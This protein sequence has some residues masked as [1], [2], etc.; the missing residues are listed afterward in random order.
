MQGLQVFS[1]PADAPRVRWRTDLI[2]AALTAVALVVLIA[3]AG[4]GS[5]LDTN[6][7]EFVGT[8][9]GWLLWLGQAIYELGVVYSLA[10]LIG[11]GLFAR[12]R[13]ELLRD[14]LL[15]A[16]LAAAIVVLLSRFIDE[17][18]PELPFLDLNETRD[19]FPAFF[20]AVAAAI[21]AAASPHLTAPMR[22]AGWTLILGAVAA[23]VLG[24]VTTTSDALG[25]LL[26]GLI[27]AALIRYLL[28]TTAG[29]PPTDRIRVALDDLG[30]HTAE[31]S[32][33]DAARQPAT[34]VVLTGTSTD[35][36][37]LF[38]RGLGRDS[39]S[40]RRWIRWWRRAWYQDRGSQ[41]GA[42]RRQQLEH[43]ALA[44][45]LARQ[46]GVPVPAFVGVGM[47][48]HEDG[49]LVT[50]WLDHTLE[51]VADVD[52]HTLDA[53]WAA[54]GASHRVGI[55]H[56]SLDSRHIWFDS[57]GAPALMGFDQAAINASDDQI[58]SDLAA[59]LVLTTLTV[60]A[61][62]AIAAARRAIGDESLA[63]MLP[64]LQ[65]AS[66]DATLRHRIKAQ[67]LKVDDLRKQTAEAL[68]TDVPA[69]EQLTRVTWK[70]LV[71]TGFVGF[72]VYSIIAGLADVGFGTI[73]DSFADARWSLVLLGLFLA[74]AT[75]Y[76]DS[77]AV[78]AVAPKP[79]PVGITTIEQFGIGF[80]NMAVPAP[81]GSIATNV[82]FFQKFGINAVA[83][84]TNGVITGF[85]G[86]AAQAIMI[87]FTILVGAGSVDLSAFEGGGDVIRPLL[88]ALVVLAIA[89][90]VAM[91]VPTWR[92]WTWHKI[93]KPL[94]Q[95]REALAALKNP[96]TAITALAGSIGT[97][98][99]YGAG[100][101]CCVLAMGGSLTLGQAIF[102][103]ITVSL[104]SAI[105][106][107]PGNAGVAEAG[108]TASLT[109][110][111]VPSST[112]VSAVLVYRLVSTYLPPIWGYFCM[113]WLVKRDYL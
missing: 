22:K 52:D 62:R 66:C 87:A 50:E 101:L 89:V 72:G 35:G 88:T 105:S 77:I 69:I 55:S 65:T 112:A 36:A 90:I 6:T 39:W 40:A 92:H 56:G 46:G 42:D 54:L 10:L 53:I 41:V 94:G 51:D 33:V 13:L 80:V 30:V 24:G 58:R 106:P 97:E 8:L 110:V 28:G 100:L 60:G 48:A 84:T 82:R 21:Q 17:R 71:M 29:L 107:V 7:L 91:L 57:S 96:R 2:S 32:Y 73:V 19:T 15:A 79:L 34:S 108:L 85:T 25:G 18:W 67:K 11:V 61:D 3:V 27:A 68:G 86:Y 104:I 102:I 76:T 75:N 78:V 5:T 16:A 37:P 9:P 113:R 20:V 83:A 14:M 70:S 1:A 45:V 99:L 109:A 4:N 74:A 31:L 47:T 38:V 81:A 43:E 26:L 59:M 111:G 44:M 103:N 23:S 98:V 95:M 64:M 63:A 12:G 49:L 93:A